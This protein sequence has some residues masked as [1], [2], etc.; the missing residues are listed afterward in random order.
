VIRV[1]LALCALMTLAVTAQ[2]EVPPG[3]RLTFMESNRAGF[4]LVSSDPGG[5]DQRVIVGGN[6]KSGLLPY[7]FSRPS[8]SGDGTRIAFTA[9]EQRGKDGKEAFLDIYDAAADG[10]GI[11]KLAGTKDGLDAVLSPDG[12]TLAFA[13]DREREARRPH[14][15]EVTIF[16]SVSIWLLNIDHGT[17]SQLTPSRRGNALPTS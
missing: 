5:G 15:G 16:R 1:V 13:R 8:W 11:T 12:S 10:T 3:P 17:I 7:P 4:K 2:A 14:R 9:I 6:L